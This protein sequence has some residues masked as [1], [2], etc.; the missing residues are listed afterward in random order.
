MEHLNQSDATSH[1]IVA[2]N[3]D[4]LKAIFPEAVT[5]GKIDFDAL[6][7]TLGEYLE[8]REERYNFSW[9]GKSK[10]RRLA[11]TPTTGTLRPCPEES[12]DWDKTENLFIEGDNLEVL[13]LLQKSYQGQVKMIYIDPPYNTGGDFVYPDKY[14]DNLKG[15]LEYTNQ[16][17]A[18]GN[19]NTS[20]A[21]TNG[22]YHSNW[23]NMMLPRLSLAK[24][25]LRNDG[26]IFVSIGQDEICNL[27]SLCNEI[28]GE[29]N[30]VSLCSRVMKTGGQKG[31]HFSPCVDYILIYAKSIINLAPFRVEISKNV[32]DKV[33]TRVS[34]SGPRSGEKYRSM[35]IYQAGLDSMRG[36]K[37]QRYYIEAPDGEL[38]I[39]PGNNFPTENREAAQV[40][41]PNQEM[42]EY[43][44]GPTQNS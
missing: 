17:D 3:I 31:T 26:A 8:T 24:N 38:V 32:I 16:V 20:N 43:G 22:R 15:Y 5:E 30:F 42:T 28:F 39:P 21:E 36:C 14:A 41:P 27:K 4:K 35:G 34:S 40:A 11:Q 13:K 10:A 2:D 6:K 37:N 44:D 18:E 9:A 25:L 7:E 33:Y 12:V 1:D 23:L 19:R 29:E